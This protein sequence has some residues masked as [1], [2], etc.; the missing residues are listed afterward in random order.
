VRTSDIGDSTTETLR[1]YRHVQDTFVTWPNGKEEL[2]RFQ[3][4][5]NNNHP[6]ISFLMETEEVNTLLLMDILF[7]S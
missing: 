6:N 1:W 7:E 4:H 3:K 2:G 5:L